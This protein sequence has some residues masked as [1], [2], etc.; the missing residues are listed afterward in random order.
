MNKL[1]SVLYRTILKPILFLFDPVWCHEI[2]ITAGKYF[3]SS[4]LWKIV[5]SKLFRKEDAVLM[6]Y[7]N[8]HSYTFPCS[9]AAWFD[10][11][12][13]L[14][15]LA[16]SLWTG[17]HVVGSL[18]ARPYVGNPWP[19]LTR[20]P[21]D[22]SI[23][24]NYGLKNK[25][26]GYHLEYLQQIS[27]TLMQ[28]LWISIAKTNCADV[29]DQSHAIDDYLTSL[30]QLQKLDQSKI[31][32]EINISC[33]NA[34]GGEDFTSP[35]ALE[36]LL[37]V[38]DELALQTPIYIKMP[39]SLPREQFQ[40]LIDVILKHKVTW[41]VIANLY[42]QRDLLS[43][44][45]NEIISCMWW[46]LSG[47][48]CYTKSL[49]YISRSYQYVGNNIT[50]V[51]CGGIFSAHDAYEMI[52]HGASLLQLITGMIYVGPQLFAEINTWIVIYLKRDWYDH[53][54]QAVWSLKWGF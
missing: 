52:C 10:K 51:W 30:M 23:L 33:P 12:C 38:I 25:W 47:K 22:Q 42:K 49:E 44:Q 54:T 3:G 17:Y 4:R 31:V 37:S 24:V 16:P 41:L 40:I 1:I 20:L 29:C 46:W 48:Q 19:R 35:D 8:G 11:G 28:P 13:D 7:I 50:I 21:E 53:I 26:I 15:E 6:Q 27:W 39:L 43:K 32:Y 2:F 14:I 34:F 45:S 36:K 9:I 18:T 5:F